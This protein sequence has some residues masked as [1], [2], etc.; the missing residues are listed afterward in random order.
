[1]RT[2]ISG[3]VFA[4]VFAV[5]LYGCGGTVSQ[6]YE[7]EAKGAGIGAATGAIA[8]GV[9]G[10]DIK[11][12]AIGGLAG[13]L[14]GGTVGHFTAE[15]EEDAN[16]TAEKYGYDQ[17]EG[18]RVRI[19]QIEI[20][21]QVASPGEKV[22]IQSTY[23]LLNPDTSEELDITESVEIRHNGDLVGSPKTTLT[24]DAGT[25]ESSVPLFLP[26]NAPEGTYE[27]TTTIR[28]AGAS[29]S[30]MSTFEVR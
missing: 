18:T 7:R 30:R 29:D 26:D 4:G 25:Y 24:H 14:I 8:G 13:A 23:A 5:S 15:K 9:L 19:E 6:D 1:M 10:G 3:I 16:T 21:P 20:D 28:A 22:E 27:V 17:D 2:K 12:A 11:G